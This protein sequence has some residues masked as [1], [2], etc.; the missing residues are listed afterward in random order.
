MIIKFIRN[1]RRSGSL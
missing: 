1:V